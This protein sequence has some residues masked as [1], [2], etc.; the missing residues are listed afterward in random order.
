MAAHLRRDLV[1]AGGHRPIP[2]VEITRRYADDTSLLVGANDPENRLALGSIRV[3]RQ[4]A[5]SLR[6][7]ARPIGLQLD[8]RVFR[9]LTPMDT[10]ENLANPEF[11]LVIA[12]P[13]KVSDRRLARKGRAGQSSGAGGLLHEVRAHGQTLGRLGVLRDHHVPPGVNIGAG[14]LHARHKGVPAITV[15]RVVGI[16]LPAKTLLPYA[17]IRASV[18]P[19]DRGSRAAPLSPAHPLTQGRASHATICILMAAR[20][21]SASIAR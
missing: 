8:P 9:M 21:S 7:V 10:V 6:V 16:T 13:S 4:S 1:E 18:C 5:G 12:H 19:S 20:A 2:G 15:E 17:E 3:S 14:L 11:K